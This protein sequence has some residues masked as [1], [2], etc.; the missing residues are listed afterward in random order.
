MWDHVLSIIKK[1]ISKPSYDTWL[2][3]TKA[4]QFTEEKVVIYA[5]NHF[6]KEWLE[7]R[8]IHIIRNSI[9]EATGNQVVDVTIIEEDSENEAKEIP[10]PTIKKSGTA[11]AIEE[12]APHMLNT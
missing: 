9:M 12:P 7:T 11:Q 3:S 5:P 10:A 1:K 2:K 8:Y 6:A 4:H